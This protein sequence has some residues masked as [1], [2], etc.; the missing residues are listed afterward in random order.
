MRSES[1]QVSDQV[2]QVRPSL[3]PSGGA[4]RVLRRVGGRGISGSRNWRPLV[5]AWGTE[6]RSPAARMEQSRIQ[7]VA[8][9]GG[10]KGPD[11]RANRTS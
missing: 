2:G 11:G 7:V 4:K 6:A 10:E 3:L 9:K 5:A 1:C 8:L